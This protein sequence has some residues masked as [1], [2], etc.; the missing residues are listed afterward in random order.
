MPGTVIEIVNAFYGRA[1]A[2]VCVDGEGGLV[3]TTCAATLEALPLECNGQTSCQLPLCE[4]I[5]FEDPCPET[6]KYF[7]AD[8]LCVAGPTST[9]GDGGGGGGGS[10][11][12]PTAP[13][14]GNGTAN[15][16]STTTTPNATPAPETSTSTEEAATSTTSTVPGDVGFT[17]AIPEQVFSDDFPEDTNWYVISGL[18]AMSLMIIVAIAVLRQPPL[19]PVAPPA[20]DP[21][22]TI[23]VFG[24]HGDDVPSWSTLYNQPVYDTNGYLDE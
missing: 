7:S 12:T 2:D 14:G 13:N 4:L 20:E 16:S 18:V 22:A 19:P 5:T 1:S 11:S 3:N 24:E 10:S 6:K 9:T 15:T 23:D 21:L 8:Y 17:T